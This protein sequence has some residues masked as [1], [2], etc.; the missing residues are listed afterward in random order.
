MLPYLGEN[1]ESDFYENLKIINDKIVLV[2][3]MNIVS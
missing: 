2:C 1:L 3:A